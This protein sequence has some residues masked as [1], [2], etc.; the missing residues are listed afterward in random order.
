MDEA[1][2]RGTNT[3]YRRFPPGALGGDGDTAELVFVRDYPYPV[4]RI[5]SSITDPEMTKLWWAEAEID[6]RVGGRFALRW[7][8]GEDGKPQ[9]WWPGEI[10]A[11]VPKRL[12]E[13][14]SEV[15]GLLRWEL[16][17]IDGGTRVTFTNRVTPGEEKYITMSLA[18]WHAHLDHLPEAIEGR[19]PRWDTWYE[20]HFPA[21][22]EVH[23]D[24]Q[25]TYQLS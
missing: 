8:N 1:N 12:L 15:H 9:E 13:H 20:V 14:T 4:E 19:A 10:T 17:P 3:D 18:G 22:E 6:L 16:E 5:W 23:A 11:L 24:Y 25:R 21:W 2:P 7:L